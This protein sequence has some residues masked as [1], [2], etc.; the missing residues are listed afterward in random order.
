MTSL[1]LE[2]F[3][4]QFIDGYLFED[5]RSMAPIEAAEGKQ[6]GAVGYPMVVST[7]SACELFGGLLSPDG[8]DRYAGKTYF[9]AFWKL[10]YPLQDFLHEPVYQLAR[11]GLAHAAFAKPLITVVKAPGLAAR[12]DLHLHRDCDGALILDSI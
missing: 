6:A 10:M 11:H 2:D 1:S 3:L 9:E 4:R 5:L 7:L 12:R 8:F